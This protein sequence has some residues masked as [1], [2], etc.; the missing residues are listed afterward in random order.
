MKTAYV[1]LVALALIFASFSAPAFAYGEA[2]ASTFAVSMTGFPDT[3]SRGQTLTGTISIRLAGVK[4]P[5]AKRQRVH[6]DVFIATS[7]EP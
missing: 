1:S 5:F 3:I 2:V 4:D 6:V 7:A